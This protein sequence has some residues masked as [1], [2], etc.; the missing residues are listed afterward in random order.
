MEG[1]F[2]SD[3]SPH[4][5]CSGR[6]F[7]RAAVLQL[8]VGAHTENIAA[9]WRADAVVCVI[10]L[11]FDEIFQGQNNDSVT[12][13]LAPMNLRQDARCQTS[14]QAIR[15]NCLPVMPTYE[16][17]AV[18]AAVL[19][20]EQIKQRRI[21]GVFVRDQQQGECSAIS[22]AGSLDHSLAPLLPCSLAP[23]ISSPS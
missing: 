13:S 6:A 4:F 23:S 7:G 21:I 10:Q 22:L 15:M 17:D 18:V 9:R 11:Y 5:Q 2:R 16:L 8:V 20:S 19:D 3:V 1:P 12:D 14:S